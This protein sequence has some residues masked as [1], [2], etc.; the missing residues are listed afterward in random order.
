MNWSAYV[1][2]Q[3][4]GSID[5]VITHFSNGTDLIVVNCFIGADNFA[6]VCFG[7]LEMVSLFEERQVSDSCKNLIILTTDFTDDTHFEIEKLATLHEFLPELCFQ[8]HGS[9]QL[10]FYSVIDQG[11]IQDVA[12]VRQRLFIHN[13][14]GVSA[15]IGTNILNGCTQ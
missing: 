6:A 15:E 11:N 9:T 5:R 10:N 4:Q 2:L 13:V 8:I 12:G 14:L 7:K 3:V 1:G